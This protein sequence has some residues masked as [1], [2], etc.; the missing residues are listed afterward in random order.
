MTAKK[1]ILKEAKFSL[2]F[3]L[4]GGNRLRAQRLQHENILP[5]EYKL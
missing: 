4:T 5:S 2:S 1:K 3:F